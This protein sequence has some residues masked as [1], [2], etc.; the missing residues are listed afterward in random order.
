M[1]YSRT[2]ERGH[3]V[4]IRMFRLSVPETPAGTDQRGVDA[5]LASYSRITAEECFNLH[6]LAV[7]NRSF[8]TRNWTSCSISVLA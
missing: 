7:N 2:R 1:P 3:I 4:R 5:D 8:G 6:W